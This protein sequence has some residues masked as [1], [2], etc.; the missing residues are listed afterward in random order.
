[1]VEFLP[2][3]LSSVIEIDQADCKYQ[4]ESVVVQG[5]V[6][7]GGASGGWDGHNGD[8]KVL[9]FSFVAWRKP[10]EPVKRQ[11]MTVL[12]PV[13]DFDPHWGS[14]EGY[15]VIR[16]RV[17]LSTD[18]FRAVYEEALP[19]DGPDAEL[20]AVATQ[21]QQD[22]VISHDTF[23]EF[24][25]DRRMDW[26]EAEVNWNGEEIRLTMEAFDDAIDPGFMATAEELWNRQSFWKKRIED[27]VVQE[28]LELKNDNWLDDDEDEVSPEEFVE[29][30]WISSVSVQENGDF[31]F[32]YDDGNLFWDHAIEVEGNIQT[33]L[34]RANIAG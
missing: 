3:G 31:V 7:E 19:L 22:V 4:D 6:A 9:T 28:L 32:W 30:I 29:R 16:V 15:S 10:G 20:N 26:F 21:L 24:K 34:S 12:R 1:M 23:G 14:Y 8:Y 13:K 33:G 18:E 2:D 27:F 25:L 11:T 17:R 5:V